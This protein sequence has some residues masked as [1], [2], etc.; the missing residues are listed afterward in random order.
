MRQQFSG[1]KECVLFAIKM[2]A[3]MMIKRLGSKMRDEEMVPRGFEPI[4][5]TPLGMLTLAEY[6]EAKKEK[7]LKKTKARV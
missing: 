3:Q 6:T 7:K 1:P 5:T 4:R 2:K